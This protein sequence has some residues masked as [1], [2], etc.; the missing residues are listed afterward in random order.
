MFYSDKCH[1]ILKKQKI[2]YKEHEFYLDVKKDGLI[3]M[4]LENDIKCIY[5]VWFTTAPVFNESLDNLIPKTTI[6]NENE[7]SEEY[8]KYFE[9]V[10]IF[11]CS[12]FQ[13]AITSVFFVR[14]QPETIN[15]YAKC[16]EEYNDK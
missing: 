7:L 9:E 3:E 8:I 14:M 2:K 11:V 16:L 5:N 15:N 1:E 6:M 13:R 12:Y 10:G 4:T